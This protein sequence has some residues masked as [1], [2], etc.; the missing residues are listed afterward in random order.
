MLIMQQE[1]K[2]ETGMVTVAVGRINDPEQADEIIKE[3]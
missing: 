3:W 1:L 2:N